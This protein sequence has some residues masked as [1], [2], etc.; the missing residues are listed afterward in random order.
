MLYSLPVLNKDA[1]A[2]THFPTLHQAFIFRACEYVP[3]EKI[4][5]VLRTDVEAVRQAAA[6][7][8]LPDYDPGDVWLKRGYIT[9]IRRMWHILPY[10]QLLELLEMDEQTLAVLMKEDDFLN[11]KLR[12]KPRCERVVWRELSNEES[13]ERARSRRLWKSLTFRES[14]RFNLNITFRISRSR[15]RNASPPV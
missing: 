8:G 3:L 13:V 14:S 12:E 7:M 1:I 15:E 6:D 4:A 10:D 5:S 11:V 9:I 2:L